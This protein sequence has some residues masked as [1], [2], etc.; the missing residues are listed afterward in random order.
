M[1]SN[2]FTTQNQK[3]EP[4]Y[5][6]EFDRELIIQSIAKQYHILPSAQENLHYSD[7]YRLVAGIMEDT[8]LGQTVLVRKED[9]K[10]IIKRMSPHEKEIRRQWF[11]FTHKDKKP[12]QA[13]IKAIKEFENMFREMFGG[14]K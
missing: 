7:W 10:D 6:L 2:S 13:N 4:F 12:K 9:N 1:K 8:P 5:D 3:S 14:E 11:E